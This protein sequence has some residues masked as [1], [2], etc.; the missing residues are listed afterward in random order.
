ML[1]GLVELLGLDLIFGQLHFALN[2]LL[3]RCVHL[4][5]LIFVSAFVFGHPH[6]DIQ[7]IFGRLGVVAYWLLGR[8]IGRREHA[9]THTQAAQATPQNQS[10]QHKQTKRDEH[11]AR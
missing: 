3:D 7:G 2:R 10:D 4:P 6:F 8:I 11:G 5:S 9:T 1:L